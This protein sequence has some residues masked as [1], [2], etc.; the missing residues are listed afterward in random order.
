M[1]LKTD[2]FELKASDICKIYFSY[3]DGLLGTLIGAL[4]YWEI[5]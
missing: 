3:L 5:L 1:D 2:S 4:S